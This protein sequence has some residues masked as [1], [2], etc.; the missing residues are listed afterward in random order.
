MFNLLND[1]YHQGDNKVIVE[2]DYKTY[3]ILNDLFQ[4]LMKADRKYAD[5]PMIEAKVGAKTIEAELVELQRE[6]ERTEIRPN[7]IKKEAVQVMTMGYKFVR[8]ICI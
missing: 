4:E 3:N 7:Q 6:C 2:M 8:D 5:D 1:F